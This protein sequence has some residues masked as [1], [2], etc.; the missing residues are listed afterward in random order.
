M[1]RRGSKFPYL[2]RLDMSDPVE[3]LR[4]LAN[5]GRCFQDVAEEAGRAF[6][7]ASDNGARLL[8]VP[9]TTVIEHLALLR[10]GCQ[11]LQPAGARALVVLAAA[12]S[13][14]F[15]PKSRVALDKIQSWNRNEGLQLAL[16]NVPKMLGQIK[17]EWCPGATVVSFK[18]ETDERLLLAKAFS[19]AEFFRGPGVASGT[20]WPA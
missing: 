11:A 12:V 1:H 7:G 18:L 3:R 10:L 16:S 9:F 2:R 19:V 14:F 4:D 8:S 20:P 5:G 15:I 13:D 17:A 6:A